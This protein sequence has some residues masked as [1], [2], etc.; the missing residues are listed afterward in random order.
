M[1]MIKVLVFLFISVKIFA[2]ENTILSYVEQNDINGIKKVIRE[3]GNINVVDENLYTPLMIA[4]KKGYFDIAKLL[5]D[6]KASINNQSKTGETALILAASNHNRD[7]V[8]LLIDN[9]ADVN[10]RDSSGNTA[11]TIAAR[12]GFPRISKMLRDAGGVE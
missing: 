9:G 12:K 5:L 6:A 8:R 7:I 3:G 4:S 11:L 1:N 2:L 10:I